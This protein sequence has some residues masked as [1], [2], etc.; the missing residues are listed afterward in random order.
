MAGLLRLRRRT[1]YRTY[2]PILPKYDAIFHTQCWLHRFLLTA[3]TSLCFQLWPNASDVISLLLQ[4]DSVAEKWLLLCSRNYCRDP[5]PHLLHHLAVLS[6]GHINQS[7]VRHFPLFFPL[8]LSFSLSAYLSFYL[9]LSNCALHFSQRIANERSVFNS[10]SSWVFRL[11]LLFKPGFLKTQ[12]V[13]FFFLREA[14]EWLVFRIFWS[15][16]KESLSCL[17]R[18]NNELFLFHI[19]LLNNSL[20]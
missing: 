17:I 4:R 12:F 11:K 20:N 5:S 13:S 18:H 1:T 3:S 15:T 9:S 10:N 6:R 19:S 8:S 16:Q 14:I 7:R 2:P